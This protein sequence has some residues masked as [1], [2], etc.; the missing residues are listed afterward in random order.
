MVIADMADEIARFSDNSTIT[1][2]NGEARTGYFA[3]R[4]AYSLVSTDLASI[5]PNTGSLKQVTVT[6]GNP[7]EVTVKFE[8][9]GIARNQVIELDSL[10]KLKTEP[11]EDKTSQPFQIYFTGGKPVALNLDEATGGNLPL[12]YELDPLSELKRYNLIFDHESGILSGTP[13]QEA[14]TVDVALDVF[15][16]GGDDAKPLCA[17]LGVSNRF[18]RGRAGVLRNRFEGRCGIFRNTAFS[19]SGWQ[20]GFRRINRGKHRRN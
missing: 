19:R 2:K 5:D 8:Y 1:L 7:P 3:R 6:S 12:R 9:A 14:F 4:G 17:R 16:S 10:P 15:D 11:E 18:A 13:Q 20:R